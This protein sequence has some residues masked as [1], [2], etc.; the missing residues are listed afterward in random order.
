M[1]AIELE[2]PA[3]IAS[4]IRVP[5]GQARQFLMQE[6]VLRLYEEG[7]I[8]SG[9]G[10]SLLHKNR[11]AFERFLA[12]HHVALHCGVDELDQDLQNLERVL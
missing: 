2:I 4:Q 7:V 5:S 9:Q 12:E 3:E 11:H 1:Q 6:L 10:A 8:T